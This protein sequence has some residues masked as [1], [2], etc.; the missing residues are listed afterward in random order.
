[1]DLVYLSGRLSALGELRVLDAMAEELTCEP[2]RAA[3][4]GF[5]PDAIVFLSSG[6][7]CLE[8]LAFLREFVRPGRLL[9]GSGDLFRDLG[10]TVL[11]LY[12]EIDAVLNDFTESAIVRF[13]EGERQEAL[14]NLI[15]RAGADRIIGPATVVETPKSF[16][17]PL[18]RW[19]L[20]PVQSYRFPFVRHH[21]FGSVLTDFGCPFHC[22]FCPIGT[23]PWRIRPVTEV[24]AEVRQL[25]E[26]GV[27]EVH[28]RD[29]T[30]G[31]PESRRA[32][33]CD[34][35]EALGVS[36]SCFSRVDVLKPAS[37][38][39]LRAAGC[40]TVIFGIESA[41]EERRAAL[42]KKTKDSETVEVLRA[43][44]R[45]GLRTVGTFILGLP[46]DT[47]ATVRDT[48]RYAGLLPLDYASFNVAMPRFGTELRRRGA[49]EPRTR[50][51]FEACL[52]ERWGFVPVERA[53]TWAAQANRAFYLNPH[54]LLR[55]ASCLRSW[56]DLLRHAGTGWSLFR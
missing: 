13:L 45:V 44:R 20:F 39:R 41:S 31:L 21:P 26:L 12:P 28:V 54:T 55:H 23:I 2:A 16:S 8:D 4:R 38:P 32:E 33:I 27:R 30:F 42:N 50:G 48:I 36:W 3:I 43:C 46:G 40:H 6:L 47:E 19:D 52:G 18:P 5:E 25:R 35:F 7:S 9:V 24:V 37:L 34:Q 10:G 56:T 29:Q 1:M 49:A 14:P 17:V 53:Q 11:R 22:S 15:Y 51:E